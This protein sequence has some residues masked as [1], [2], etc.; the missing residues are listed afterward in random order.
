[1]AMRVTLPPLAKG[2]AL[3]LLAAALLVG[4]GLWLNRGSQTRL[5]GA[6]LK[7]RTIATDEAAAIVVLDAR[8]GNPARA[9][10]L[11]REVTVEVTLAGGRKLE[12]T[13]VPELDLDRVLSYYPLTGPRFNPVL[14]AREKLRAAQTADR[15]IA[16]SFAVSE[17]ELLARR[18]LVV[19]IVDADGAVAEIAEA[20][21]R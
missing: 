3:G 1:M 4:V 21:G 11:V 9:L 10:F 5:A 17:K 7:V 16:A 12:G 20:A 15:T 2:L 8:I 18:A 13:T 14:K 6:I 19:R